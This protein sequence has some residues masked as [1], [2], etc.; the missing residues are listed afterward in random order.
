MMAPRIDQGSFWLPK[1]SS[2]LAPQV[3]TAWTVVLWVSIFFFLLI[4]GAT[5][6]LVIRYRRRGPNDVT[7]PISHNWKLEFTWTFIP[8]LIVI[9][10]FFVGYTGYLNASVAPAD[11]YEIQVVAQKWSWTFVYPNGTVSPSHLVIP[12]D[13]PVRL[14]MSSKDIVHS[15]WIPEFRVKQDVLPGSYTSVWFEATEV[16]ETVL[17]CTEYCGTG[18][19][20]MLATVSVLEQPDF[21]KW[22]ESGGG[23]EKSLPPAEYGKQ[24]YATWGCN[25]CHSLDGAKGN[26]PTFQ[27]LF[28]ESVL[29]TNGAA[30]KVDED[31]VRE[32]IL[33]PQAKV[34]QG[35]QPIMP[36]FKG[37]LKDQQI[38][39]LI[40][41]IKAQGAAPAP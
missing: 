2:T 28:G 7:S 31:Y 30:V 10:L 1:Q 15:L 19:S 40:A 17:Q 34:V 24:L 29:L 21:T 6:Y 18:H 36:T 39:A 33:N 20:Q 8:L 16:R 35:F 22:L 26:G 14:V 23:Q 9:G 11:A 12:K 3:D 5:A 27:H 38:D 37:Q 32:S 4:V 25:A 41:F 13:R